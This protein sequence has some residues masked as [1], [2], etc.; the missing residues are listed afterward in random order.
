M[1]TGVSSSQ[2]G[3]PGASSLFTETG[4]LKGNGTESYM[5]GDTGTSI[6]ERM[7]VGQLLESKQLTIDKNEK[8]FSFGET[9]FN[10]LYTT[11][12]KPHI[13]TAMSGGMG[14]NVESTF[15][16]AVS[17]FTGSY[18]SAF[19][20]LVKQGFKPDTTAVS[21][22]NQAVLTDIQSKGGTKASL[23]SLADP[24]NTYDVY[25]TADG[26]VSKDPN[27][28]TSSTAA[29]KTSRSARPGV[30]EVAELGEKRRAGAQAA[31]FLG[32]STPAKTPSILSGE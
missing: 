25:K 10:D 23:V 1:G 17:N 32:L 2:Y 7:S 22:Y 9:N 3:T 14:K 19:T 13:D 12:M 27:E 21:F 28:K 24:N 18:I 20:D 8:T 6:R 16:Q 31:S 15:Q 5:P 26:W 4:D 29:E 30:P 11:A